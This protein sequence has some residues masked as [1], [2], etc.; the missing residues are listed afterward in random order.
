VRARALLAAAASV[1]VRFCECHA[2]H[3]PH[4]TRLPRLR[5]RRLTSAKVLVINVTGVTAE[6]RAPRRSVAWRETHTHARETGAVFELLAL[7][8]ARAAAHA[9]ADAPRRGAACAQMCKNIALAGVGCLSLLD[10]T[11]ASAAPPGNFLVPCDAPATTT[12]VRARLPA[13]CSRTL[14][15]MIAPPWHAHTPATDAP[16]TRHRAQRGASERS[17]AG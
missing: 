3:A 17:D 15:A 7:R 5:L 1:V 6:A 13:C 2:K 10:A 12:C 4:A 9:H 11:P 8:V 16:H 14:A